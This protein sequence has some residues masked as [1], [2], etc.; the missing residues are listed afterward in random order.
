MHNGLDAKIN[1]LPEGVVLSSLRS[2]WPGLC[3][4]TVRIS[5]SV[6]GVMVLSSAKVES[7]PEVAKAVNQ[8]F[9]DLELGSYIR[10]PKVTGEYYVFQ[11][12]EFP[13]QSFP[14]RIRGL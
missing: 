3:A 9:T 8:V 6:W 4:A 13:E 2:R 7:W 10:H 1:A 5:D 14:D 11:L 12:V